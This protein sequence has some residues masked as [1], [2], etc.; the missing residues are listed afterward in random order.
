MEHHKT[1][2]W[3]DNATNQ[4]PKLRTKKWVE[5][6][7]ESRGKYDSIIYRCCDA[8][9]WFNRIESESLW[10]YYRNYLNDKIT[11]SD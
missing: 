8:S 3:A 1:M 6:N 9:I 4:T 11:Y 5:I 2:N 10:Q 7:D